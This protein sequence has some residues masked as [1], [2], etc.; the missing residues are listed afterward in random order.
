ML[1]E[2]SEAAIGLVSEDKEDL[3]LSV[4]A[5]EGVAIGPCGGCDMNWSFSMSCSC[6]QRRILQK[7]FLELMW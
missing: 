4:V 5:D 6:L 1:A 2:G 7:L 3:G